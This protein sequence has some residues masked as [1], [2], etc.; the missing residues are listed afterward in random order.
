MYKQGKKIYG[1]VNERI[2]DG[3]L[4][5]FFRSI[6]DPKDEIKVEKGKDKK[7]KITKIRIKEEKWQLSPR[8]QREI[9]TPP[10]LG[11]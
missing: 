3:K 9:G 11:G 4:V 5:K 10:P 7:D 8:Q 6:D 2:I 1:W